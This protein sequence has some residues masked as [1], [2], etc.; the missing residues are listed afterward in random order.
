[1]KYIKLFENCI[2]VRGYNKSIICDLQNQNFK[3]IPNDLYD[4]LNDN[5]KIS[6]E[7][8]I[9]NYGEKNTNIINEYIDF[10]MKNNF[11]FYCDEDIFYNFPKLNCEYDKSSIIEN[12]ILDFNNKTFSMFSIDNYKKVVSELDKLGCKAVMLRFFEDSINNNVKN[13]LRL[14]ENTTIS[15]IVYCLSTMKTRMKIL[16]VF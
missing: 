6:L 3:H 5:E 8:L 7:I 1:M 2:P 12:S 10:L 4:I 11:A 9:N 14:F 15:H 16:C 13:I